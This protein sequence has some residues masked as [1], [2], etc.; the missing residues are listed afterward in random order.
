MQTLC[1]WS[2]IVSRLA[3]TM[4]ADDTIRLGTYLTGIPIYRTVGNTNAVQVS[5]G[6]QDLNLTLCE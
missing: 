5:I 6:G 1:F 3:H 4:A 2:I